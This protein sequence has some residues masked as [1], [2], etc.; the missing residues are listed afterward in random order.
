MVLSDQRLRTGKLLF[1]QTVLL[2]VLQFGQ[3]ADLRMQRLRRLKIDLEE[4]NITERH[5]A[6]RTA[7]EQ[8][9]LI[10]HMLNQ[11][12]CPRLAHNGGRYASAACDAAGRRSRKASP[13]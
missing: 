6:G 9:C 3:D 10:T 12:R 7:G 1:G 8:A 11:C 2:D 5:Q 4:S 13:K